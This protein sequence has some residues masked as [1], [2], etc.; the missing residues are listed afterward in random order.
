VQRNFNRP[1]MSLLKDVSRS[2]YLTLRVLPAAIRGQIGLAYLLAR[3]T[4]TIADT[5]LVPLEHRLR[6]LQALRVGILGADE[7]SVNL[8][9]LAH[10]Q[11]LP[12]ERALLEQIDASV[13]LLRNFTPADRRLVREV[14]NTIT[15]GQE[16]D[17]RRFAGASAENVTC[18]R[19]DQELEDYTY[20]VAG[21]VGEFWTNM[22]RV[23]IFPQ[24]P[25]D[26]VWLLENAVRFGKGLQLVN[27]LR[28]VAV[29]VRQG[30]CYLPGEGLSVLGLGPA[31]LLK[32]EN[33]LCLR[34]LYNSYLDKAE[35][36][37]QAGWDYTNA[38]PWRNIRVRLAC[39]WP[40]LIG[41]ETVKGLRVGKVLDPARRVKVSRK[42]V[43]RLLWR[44]V[45]LYPWPR[46]WKA[47]AS[48]ANLP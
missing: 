14:L 33:E 48:A 36:H 44:S 27:I 5:E 43:R 37:L 21:C 26:D 19:T 34:P 22:C 15:S 3:A 12:A 47:I 17:L 20:R 10:R 1:P 11:D 40:I 9:D 25:L 24:A 38:L 2:F 13:K 28:D 8:G 29:D 46:G 39:A 32:P 35:K 18:L 45:V 16:L 6:A 42:D 7:T 30:R 23:H 31:D 4:D 41:L